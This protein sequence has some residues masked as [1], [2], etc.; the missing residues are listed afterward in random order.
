MIEIHPTAVV[1]RQA[2]IGEGTTIGPNC[3]VGPNVTLGSHCVLHNNATIMGRTTVGDE[4]VFFPYS[5]VGAPPQ[6]LKYRGGETET[7]IGDDNIF[8]ENVTVHR[9]T[10][11][12]GGVTRIGH[13]N[14]FLVGSHVAHDVEIGDDCILANHVQ[15]AGHVKVED[16][17]VMGGLVGVHHF[18]T[19][20]TMAYIAGLTRVTFDIPPFM[21]VK[22]YDARIRGI[23]SEGMS[24]WHYD[25]GR[26]RKIRD[27]YR[28]LFPRRASEAEGTVLERIERIESNGDM[29]DDLRRLFNFIKRSSSDGIF[30]RY[31]ESLRTDSDVDRAGFYGGGDEAEPSTTTEEGTA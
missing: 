15:L 11:L 22:G 30:G 29:N 3:C 28:A 13:H 31:R 8:R 14:R 1:D 27:A 21:V 17:V 19:I 4:C 7:V 12:A 18:V 26:I 25:E 23:N 6:D 16:R 9:G 10:E 24:R 2:E 20:G 5:C